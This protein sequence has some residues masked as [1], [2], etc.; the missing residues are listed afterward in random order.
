MATYK[1]LPAKV[2]V[3]TSSKPLYGDLPYVKDELSGSFTAT[4]GQ[5]GVL[6]LEI[7]TCGAYNGSGRY[8]R[9]ALKVEIN[10][11]GLEKYMYAHAGGAGG[12]SGS[13]ARD[14]F[15]INMDW[16][17]TDLTPEQ[18]YTVTWEVYR[19]DGAT[20]GLEYVRFNGCWLGL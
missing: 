15:S 8:I 7:N 5:Q 4:A 14:G 18:D 16:V 6:K 17:R 20:S 1:E 9:F 13:N 11:G 19:D 3:G 2:D 12:G 10:P